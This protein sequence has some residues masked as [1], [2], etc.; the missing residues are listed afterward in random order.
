MAPACAA[1]ATV[2]VFLFRGAHHSRARRR[3]R[4]KLLVQLA[5][6]AVGTFRPAPVGGT[7]E[8][9]AVAPA[10]FAMK[11]VDRHGR[12]VN[13]AAGKFKC[14]PVR[15]RI[16]RIRSRLEPL[17]HTASSPGLRPPS[18]PFRME[19]RDGERWCPV[20]GGHRSILERLGNRIG[21][22]PQGRFE[23]SPALKCR[24]VL[25]CS[26]GTKERRQSRSIIERRPLEALLFRSA[27]R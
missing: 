6:T 14:F 13:E 21:L 8:D 5:G 25:K 22:V 3:E 4:G 11:F 20:H 17:N 2:S 23:N 12:R 10:L 9:F 26:C 7:H 18:P 19:E 1:T 27:A 24:A 16:P 15:E